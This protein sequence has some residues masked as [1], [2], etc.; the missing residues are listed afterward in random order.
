MA[1]PRD[2]AIVLVAGGRGERF[3]EAAGKQLA[4]VAGEPMLGHSLKACL[5]VAR[6]ALVV[7]T[8][9]PLR[10]EEYAASLAGVNGDSEVRFIAGGERR[11]DSVAAGLAEVPPGAVDY[12]AVHDGAR[13]LVTARTFEGA[14]DV[15]DGH[16][17]LAGVVVGHPS[18]DTLK[19]VEDQLIVETPDRSRYWVS[20][21]PQIFREPALRASYARAF[22]T[23]YEGT[24][25]ASF[26][27]VAGESVGVCEGPRENIKVTVASDLRLV[28]AVLAARKRGDA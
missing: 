13:P 21:T 8:C 19:I 7:V 11:Q 25:D 18:F 20:Q 4:V 23:G 1:D 28:E 27:E 22:S 17:D 9:D 14:L 10:V 6:V 3:G 2:T 12:I 26:V 15:L 24:D 5:S 16:P